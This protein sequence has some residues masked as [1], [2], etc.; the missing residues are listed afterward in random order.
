LS[1]WVETIGNSGAATF[2]QSGGANY[3]GS[4]N[5]GSHPGSVGSYNL[6]GAGLLWSRQVVV[7]VSGTGTFAQS[8]G[9]NGFE[10]LVELDV[11]FSS[12]YGTYSLSGSGV[13]LGSNE[14][15]GSF[16][17]GTFNQMDGLNSTAYLTIGTS[18]RYQFT[19]GT[20]QVTRFG[21]LV[22]EG[23]FDASG[24]AGL[25]SVS[26]SAIIDF[27]HAVPINSGSMSLNIGPDSLLIVPPGYNLSSA[28]G[29]FSIDPTSIVHTV[30]TALTVLPGQGFVGS[31]TLVDFVDCRGAIF[32]G[33]GAINLKGGV[34]VSGTGQV[35]LGSGTLTV[36]NTTSGISGR[37]LSEFG[38][39]VG[40]SGT[41]A[42]TQS[43]GTHTITGPDPSV[44][45]GGPFYLG[46]NAG[47]YGNY[48]LSGGS[49]SSTSETVG[50]LGIGTFTQTG[51]TNNITSV[52]QSAGLFLGSNTGS[53]GSYNLSGSALL[54]AWYENVGNNA[55]IG[56]FVQSGG[57]NNARLLGVGRNGNYTLS[58]SGVITAVYEYTV[59]TFTQTGGTNTIIGT[60]PTPFTYGTY[61]L[62]GGMLVLPTPVNQYY[63]A[64]GVFN[65]NGGTLRASGSFS[66]PQLT[67]GTSGSGATIDTAGFNVTLS[68][69]G[70][71]SLTK[72]GSGALYLPVS[73]AYGGNTLIGGGTLALG[74][75]L[76][77]QN[78]TLD[79]SGSGV[80]SFGS[81]TA[82]T[83]GGLTGAG[84]LN[85]TN[86]ASAA[87]ALSVGKNGT[88]TTYGGTLYGAGSLIKIGSGA[89][90]LTGSN[91]Y[92]GT[93]TINQGALIVNGSLV[94]PVTV[95]VPSGSGGTLGGV[96]SLTSVTVNSGGQ[97]APGDSP[98]TLV[99]S[100]SL[101]LM[102][103]AVMDYELSTPTTSDVI[104]MPAGTLLLNGQQF[105]DFS[106]TPLSRFGPG[107]FTLIDAG[108]ISGSLGLN[109]SGTIDGLPA[110]LAIQ[111]D[112]LVLTVVPEPGT[113][114]LLVVGAIVALCGAL[115][116]C[117]AR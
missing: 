18:G 25:L 22:T 60:D 90:T 115:G 78:S 49:L 37:G 59:G 82:G 84:S 98:G 24:S 58:G 32:G 28:L 38:L 86:S 88:S 40:Y 110:T 72:I 73:N 76:G 117:N 26:G 15:I 48:L 2:T 20:L 74:N 68:L 39:Y 51:G 10:N 44:L 69:S 12:G 111:G 103:G 13:V 79:T 91:I 34:S 56:T 57:T 106:F 43:S 41:G 19:G 96:G 107:A 102:P 94:S 17:S 109:T 70:S 99:L 77:L 65:F 31:T 105:S 64:G 36:D 116:R 113:L 97:L 42:F 47:S 14:N 63:P 50:Y 114:G 85:L 55:A 16:G 62:N 33:H 52:S 35:D 9:T 53:R 67:I 71:G 87:V 27:S 101:T 89:L 1:G 100:G 11:G 61:D 8:G 81:L 21:G 108:S 3:S 6:S 30:G 112:N 29:S 45:A 4:V 92:S 93:T 83:L 5:L 95:G 75:S 46:Y 7:G 104:S 80:L 54:T 66:F 23:V